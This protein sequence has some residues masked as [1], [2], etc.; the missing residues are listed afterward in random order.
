MHEQRTDH[1]GGF[2]WGGV[3]YSDSDKDNPRIIWDFCVIDGPAITSVNGVPD[4]GCYEFKL[5]A[6]V[7]H[8]TIGVHPRH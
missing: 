6:G 2:D 5:A 7:N 3:P 8:L 1:A 4:D